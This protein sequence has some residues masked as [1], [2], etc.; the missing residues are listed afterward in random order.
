MEERKQRTIS[1]DSE[2]LY[3]WYP[4]DPTVQM[5]SHLASILSVSTF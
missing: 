4:T 5:E 3:N 2:F 1:Y